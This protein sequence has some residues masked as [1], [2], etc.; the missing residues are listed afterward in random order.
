M[1]HTAP[2]NAII[3]TSDEEVPR[4]KW[5]QLTLAYDG[6]S[7]AN[8][9]FLYVDGMKISMYNLKDKLYKDIIFYRDQEPGLQVGGWWRGTGFKGGKV[10]DIVVFDRRLTDFEISI[11]ADKTKW[12]SIAA[13][14]SSQLSEKEKEILSDY[15]ISAIDKEVQK[16]LVELKKIRTEL[17]DSMRNVKEI[18]VMEEMPMPKKTTLLVRGQYNLPGEQVY[19]NTPADILPYSSQYPKNR[20]GLAMWLTDPNHPLTARV[21]VNRLWQQFFGM[22]LVKT[23][24][25]F[26]NQGALPSHPE[27]LDWLAV[28]FRESGWDMKKMIR[29]I[30]LS[31]TYKQDSYVSPSLRDTDPENR[32]L[33]RGPSARLT[34]EMIR[35][36]ALA[37][38]GLINERIGGES[39]N[40]Y[41]P[42]GLW[43][44]N[45]ASYRA[46]STD[47]MYRRSLY[48]VAKR[49]V[50]NP[51][52][53]TFD[54]SER[55]SCLSRRQKTNTPLQALVTLNDPTFIE[56]AKVLGEQ[57]SRENNTETAIT[58][59]YRKLTG[60]KPA[61]REMEILSSL[62]KIELEKFRANPS[63]A[64]GWLDAGIYKVDQNIEGALIAAN[65]VVASTIMNSDATITKR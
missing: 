15:Y 4:E 12:S 42:A 59:A 11:L 25:D 50:P 19:P 35:D 20:L 48:I 28:T 64:K 29:L 41:Q 54:A 14:P 6:S 52:L 44:I 55:S 30:V 33:A 57:M 8:G 51:T 37:A 3:K 21:A 43:E 32:L 26:G 63:K 24:E 36:N 61:A 31:D 13:K 49:T 23:S 47:D 46:D 58:T 16:E 17:S 62:Q 39:M 40:P 65:T 10:D 7:K 9:F 56:A 27:L 53:G 2:S 1:A 34:A 18:M 5:I 22:G 60:R 45:S 38:S